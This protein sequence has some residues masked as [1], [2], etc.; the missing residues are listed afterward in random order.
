MI[1]AAT[2]FLLRSLIKYVVKVQNV[3]RGTKSPENTTQ[4]APVFIIGAPRTGSTLLYQLL[5]STKTFCYINNLTCMFYENITMGMKI[6]SKVLTKNDKIHLR[7][8][9]GRT[10]G[11]YSPS[12]CGKL[13][14]RWFTKNKPYTGQPLNSEKSKIEMAQELHAAMHYSK[15]PLLIKNLNN[16][17]R[18]KTLQK[19]FPTAKFIWIKRNHPDTIQSIIQAKR[20]LGVPQK[21]TWSVSPN[22]EE[23][24]GS[25][26]AQVKN[27]ISSIEHIIETDAEKQ[28]LC[29]CTYEN[30]VAN[31]K[32]TLATL[33]EFLGMELNIPSQ[34]ESE[35]SRTKGS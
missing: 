20:K 35:I 16:S 32:T 1:K 13:W 24:F 22:N 27:Q 33:S 28:N 10:N 12:E 4:F 26:L 19:V 15:K 17:L 8:D 6:S 3:I 25:E 5:C 30:L 18:I 7:S 11:W 29:I 14:Y 9:L 31:P 23:A 21:V 2:L 34:I